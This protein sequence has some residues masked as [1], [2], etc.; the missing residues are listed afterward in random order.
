MHKP[1]TVHYQ[2]A[3]RVLRYLSGSMNQGIL[4]ANQSN[5]K[6]SAFCDSDWAGCPNTR[7]STSGFCLLLGK[8]PIS[9][10]SKRQSVVARSTAEAEYRSLAFTVCEVLWMKQLL[11]DLGLKQLEPTLVHCDNQAALAIAANLVHIEKTKHVEIDYH[12]VRDKA[13]EGVIAP[14]YVQSSQQIADIFTKILPVHQHQLLMS[15]LGVQAPP[16]LLP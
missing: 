15:K 6:L 2:S 10:K 4:L 13:K 3:K 7:R 1:T 11:K 5:V 16:S 14:T 9:W 12:F 8:S